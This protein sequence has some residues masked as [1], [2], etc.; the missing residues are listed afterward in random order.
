[1]R[2]RCV[3]IN[4]K[5]LDY[6]WF[7]GRSDALIDGL[8]QHD[9]DIVCFQESTICQHTP[10]YNQARDIGAALGLE[11]CIFGP[12]GNPAEIVTHDQGGIALI[13][14]FAISDVRGRRLP[15]GHRGQSDAR[16]ALFVLLHSPRGELG[17][18]TT[19]LSW[20]PEE[21]EVRLM[22]MGLLLSEISRNPWA[23]SSEKVILLGDLNATS[24]EPAIQAIFEHMKD[25]FCVAHPNEPGYTWSSRN[26]LTREVNLADRRIDYIF[27]DRNAT[28]RT[29][30]VILDKPTPVFPSDHFGIFAELEWPEQAAK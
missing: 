12:Y 8:R 22:Q 6:G 10:I 5:G 14:R 28:I 23:P 3:T 11:N 29:C 21:A 16:S 13:S 30:D 18:I 25:A 15:P 2:V 1:M 4:L 17:V 7:E 26:P 27:S 19:H 9:P 20:R 24:E